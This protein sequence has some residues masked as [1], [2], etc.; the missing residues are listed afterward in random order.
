MS[1]FGDTDI[2]IIFIS[3]TLK[4]FFFFYDCSVFLCI[5]SLKLL[6]ADLFVILEKIQE[7]DF[8]SMLK[9]EREHVIMLVSLLRDHRY[10]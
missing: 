2:T 7:A 4:S 9:Q 6:V 3:I 8:P 5:E 10:L 1:V